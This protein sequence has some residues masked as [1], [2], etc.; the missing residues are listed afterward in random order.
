MEMVCPPMDD[1]DVMCL[2]GIDCVVSKGDKDISKSR[3]DGM[4]AANKLFCRPLG[5]I[6]LGKGERLC[7]CEFSCG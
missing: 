4:P 7:I 6:K 5:C 2:V 3:R 1:N